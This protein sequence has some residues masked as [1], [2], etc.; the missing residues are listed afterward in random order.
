MPIRKKSQDTTSTIETK[1]ENPRPAVLSLVDSMIDTLIR[2][3]LV[4]CWY[5]TGTVGPG[6]SNLGFCTNSSQSSH[7]F[8]GYMKLARTLYA[9][10]GR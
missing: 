5:I 8:D 10:Y 1:V 3:V 4:L 7:N 9:I 6:S 2:T